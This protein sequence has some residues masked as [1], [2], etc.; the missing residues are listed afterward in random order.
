[1]QHLYMIFMC[2]KE[3]HYKLEQYPTTSQVKT[4]QG[5]GITLYLC[6][7]CV[8][9]RRRE[10]LDASQRLTMH[11]GHMEEITSN[12]LSCYL[13]HTETEAPMLF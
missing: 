5:C 9:Q 11:H 6:P 3:E 7:L 12:P 8:L 13:Q 4:L 1:M 2:R 10:V